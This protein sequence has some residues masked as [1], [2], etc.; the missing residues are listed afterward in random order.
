[1]FD[2]ALLYSATGTSPPASSYRRTEDWIAAVLGF[3]P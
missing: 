3:A 2:Q 1:M